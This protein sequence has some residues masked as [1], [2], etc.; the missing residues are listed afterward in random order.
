DDALHAQQT[1]AKCSLDQLPD[2][3]NAPVSKVVDVVVVPLSLVQLHHRGNDLDQVLVG[4]NTLRHG[5]IV[6]VE[7]LVQLVAPDLAQIVAAEVEEQGVEESARVINR[8]RVA[9]TQ[10]TVK[11]KERLFHGL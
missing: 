1:N 11:F 6:K 10:P 5:D 4:E 7:A 2:G 9:R 3:A 8:W